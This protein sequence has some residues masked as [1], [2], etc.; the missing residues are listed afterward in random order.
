[1]KLIFL[2]NL[3]S[4]KKDNQR[5]QFQLTFFLKKTITNI[6]C[7]DRDYYLKLT[8]EFVFTKVAKK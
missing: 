4:Y 2:L 1:M 5:L 3:H 8:L 7:E 6:H